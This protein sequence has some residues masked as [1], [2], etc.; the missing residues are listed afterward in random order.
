M[1]NLV[2]TMWL[3]RYPRPTE[4]MYDQGSE[5]I[6]HEFRKFLI[7][8]KYRITAKRTTLGIPTSNVTLEQTQQV[9]V[10]LLRNFN[11]NQTYVEEDY[12]WSGILDAAEFSIRPTTN[13]L[14]C[15]ILGQLLFGCD[16]ILLIK[17][18]VDWELIRQKNQTKINK[19]NIR[20]NIKQVDHD[21]KV[22]DKVILNNKAA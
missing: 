1:A 3:S 16:M 12:P 6:G 22:G 10:N 8:I 15:Y 17:Y 21:Y 5:F 2:E 20:K 4:I 11:I 18:K 14:K 7:E 19:D 13:R 9:L